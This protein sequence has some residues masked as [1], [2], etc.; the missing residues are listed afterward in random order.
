MLRLN[1]YMDRIIAMPDKYLYFGPRNFS[2]QPNAQIVLKTEKKFRC[3]YIICIIL[4]LVMDLVSY[5][6]PKFCCHSK[7]ACSMWPKPFRMLIIRHC[8][9]NIQYQVFHIIIMI[10]CLRWQVN[11]VFLRIVAMN[12]HEIKQFNIWFMQYSTLNIFNE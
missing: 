1:R 7:S 8:Q 11:S 12:G 10:E 3:H 4:F 9:I 6:Y 2:R 5:P